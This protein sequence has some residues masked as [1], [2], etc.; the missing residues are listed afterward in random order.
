MKTKI[1]LLTISDSNGFCGG[2]KVI[3]IYELCLILG[4]QSKKKRDG[5]QQ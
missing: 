2:K 5:Y 4:V 3:T 1:S